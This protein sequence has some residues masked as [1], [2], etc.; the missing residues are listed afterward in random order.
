MCKMKIE[1]SNFLTTFEQLYNDYLTTCK[2]KGLSEKTVQ[3]YATHLKCFG[4]YLDLDTPIED[5]TQ[6]HLE[7]MVNQ[8][9]D[10]GLSPNTIRSYLRSMSC[11]FSCLGLILIA[12]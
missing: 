11:F 7:Q 5:L 12:M 10:N 1:I 9:R 6:K 8:M 2:A 4:K 3:S